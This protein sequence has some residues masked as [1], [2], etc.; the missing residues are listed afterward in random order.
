MLRASDIFDPK[1]LF[2]NPL[3]EL[4]NKFKTVAT[5]FSNVISDDQIPQLLDKVSC[6][7]V[8]TRVKE[9]AAIL[10]PVQIFSRLLTWRGGKY[11]LVGRLGC[12]LLSVH[13]SGA[14]A[15]R[16]FSL[17]VFKTFE[18]FYLFDIYL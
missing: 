15:E 7:Q 11:S 1:V 3:D 12:A 14:M 5:R 6:L 4:K 9:M 18:S 17:Q 8:K 2:T 10:T 13:N 16:D